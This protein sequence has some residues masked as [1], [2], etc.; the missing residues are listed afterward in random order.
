MKGRKNIIHL[1]LGFFRVYISK[2]L[3]L[4]RGSGLHFSVYIFYSQPR[5]CLPLNTAH[6]IVLNN[7]RGQLDSHCV[8]STLFAV[9]PL[10]L[11]KHNNSPY[12]SLSCRLVNLNL[13]LNLSY[14]HD[15]RE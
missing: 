13:N 2:R 8:V 15:K 14:L 12:S 7:K 5:A 9:G 4:A 3:D 1:F 10:I 11:G 6:S